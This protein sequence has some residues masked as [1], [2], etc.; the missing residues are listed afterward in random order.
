MTVEIE[1][2]LD[3]CLTCDKQT[4]GEAYCCSGCRLADLE[5]SSCGS[6]PASPIVPDS[7]MPLP[8]SYNGT[9]LHLSPALD[10]S[11]Y[12]THSSDSPRLSRDRARQSANYFS[13]QAP[14]AEVTR[15][16]QILSPSSSRSSLSSDSSKSPQTCQLSAQARSELRGYSNSFDLIRNWR[17]SMSSS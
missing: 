4:P 15:V 16:G 17:R 5:T 2:S 9:G 8:A 1:W 7:S 11:I 12:K 10:F 3:Y 6:E 14:D 13:T